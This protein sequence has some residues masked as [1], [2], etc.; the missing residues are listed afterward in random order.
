MRPD[1]FPK[2]NDVM[3]A[4]ALRQLLPLAEKAAKEINERWAVGA[5]QRADITLAMWV[6]QGRGRAKQLDGSLP[7]HAA[8]FWNVVD[9]PEH[10]DPGQSVPVECQRPKRNRKVN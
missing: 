3:L 10:P 9:N 6:R 2:V 8:G 7:P 1:R 4:E 5:L